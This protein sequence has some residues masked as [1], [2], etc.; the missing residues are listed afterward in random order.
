LTPAKAALMGERIKGQIQSSI[1]A[2]S[3][4]P[5]AKS[6]VDK[7]GFNDPLVWSGDKLNS[8]DYGG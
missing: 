5:N 7:K 6:T 1:I 4:P 2:F 8:V 3:E